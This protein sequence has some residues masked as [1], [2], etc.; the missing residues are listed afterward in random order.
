MRT[1]IRNV[2]IVPKMIESIVGVCITLGKPSIKFKLN[3]KCLPW[4]GWNR[5]R[6]DD[7]ARFNGGINNKGLKKKKKVLYH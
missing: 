1:H 6:R 2:I 5:E 7:R 3:K 4:S